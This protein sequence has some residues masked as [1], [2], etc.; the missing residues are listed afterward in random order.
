[1]GCCNPVYSQKKCICG[2]DFEE[3]V[4]PDK[5]SCFPYRTKI[6]CEAPPVPLPECDDADA[7][8]VFTPD[9]TPP[10]YIVATIFDQN[11]DPITDQDGINILTVIK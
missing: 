2:D 6:S 7:Y 5:G 3:P 1:M 11:C 4:N 8:A 9:E 10:F